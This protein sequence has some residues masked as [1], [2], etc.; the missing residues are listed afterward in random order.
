[1]TPTECP[2]D[3]SVPI[4]PTETPKSLKG[5]LLS[6]A[7]TVT[8]GLML[9]SWYVGVRIAAAGADTARGGSVNAPQPVETA[10]AKAVASWY[11]APRVQFYLQ[12]AGIGPER[13][14]K[15]VGSLHA[16]G[17]HAEVQ[18]GGGGNARI[19]IGPF[20]THAELQQ[21]QQDLQSAGVLAVETRN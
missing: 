8:V 17:F 6:F 18:P 20:S 11:V 10:T 19:L 7:I 5:L 14:A 13:D 21:V 1:M 15:V 16:R 2:T 4:S 3:I 12:A 9:A